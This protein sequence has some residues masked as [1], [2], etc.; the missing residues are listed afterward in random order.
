[1]ILHDLGLEERDDPSDDNRSGGSRG[2]DVCSSAE[3]ASSD[4]DTLVAVERSVWGH[5]APPSPGLLSHHD[6]GDFR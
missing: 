4:D 1:M 5:S 3:S 2:S 6:F